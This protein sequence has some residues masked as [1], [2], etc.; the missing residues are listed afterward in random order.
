MLEGFRDILGVLVY[1]PVAVVVIGFII[2]VIAG[3][4]GLIRN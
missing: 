1:V 3:I 4:V 2:A